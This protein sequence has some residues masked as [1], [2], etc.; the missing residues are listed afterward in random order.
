MILD[1]NQ[2]ISLVTA[3]LGGNLSV[4][5]ILFGVLGFIY[6]IYA[7]FASPRTPQAPV[8][9]MDIPIL[10]SPV[11]APLARIARLVFWGFV[12]SVVVAGGCFVWFLYPFEWLLL[13]VSVGLL[14]EFISL[15]GVGFFVVFK[16]MSSS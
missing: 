6:A 3:I 13:A 14:I 10:P 16:L 8:N 11:L 1:Q 5:A 4:A 12:L 7:S 9:Q 2:Q 15:L